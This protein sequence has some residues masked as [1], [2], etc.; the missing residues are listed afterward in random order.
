[1]NDNAS[2]RRLL[3][4]AAIISVFFGLLLT[5]VVIMAIWTEFKGENTGKWVATLSVLFLVSLLLFNVAR[6][7]CDP[8]KPKE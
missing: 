7:Y 2:S 4:V 5:L 8:A 6:G 3:G 1:M